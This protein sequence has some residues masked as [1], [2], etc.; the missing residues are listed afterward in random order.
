MFKVHEKFNVREV[1]VRL[2]EIMQVYR[3]DDDD[4]TVLMFIN[5]EYLYVTESVED[6]LAAIDG[7][8]CEPFSLH[9]YVSD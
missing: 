8:E 1:W 3:T 4:Y 9:G 7:R 6:I 2:S 5:G